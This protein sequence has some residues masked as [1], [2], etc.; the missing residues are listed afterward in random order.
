[1]FKPSKEYLDG[2]YL[3]QYMIEVVIG[4]KR[5]A[6]CCFLGSIFQVDK[7]INICGL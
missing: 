7:K 6:P 2:D 3:N 1:M 5:I 4:K